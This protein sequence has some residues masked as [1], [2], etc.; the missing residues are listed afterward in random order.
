M[1]VKGQLVTRVWKMT[2]PG[3]DHDVESYFWPLSLRGKQFLF[4]YLLLFGPSCRLK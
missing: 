3:F 4:L 2:F 1:G